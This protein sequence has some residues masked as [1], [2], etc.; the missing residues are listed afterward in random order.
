MT[1]ITTS[2]AQAKLAQKSGMLCY[3][4]E[5]KTSFLVLPT[6]KGNPNIKNSENIY[7]C[8]IRS[9]LNRVL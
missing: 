6:K 1:V 8:Y 5:S 3:K 4:H 2:F 9:V 7:P